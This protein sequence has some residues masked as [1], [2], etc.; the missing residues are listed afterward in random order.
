MQIAF[1]HLIFCLY[2]HILSFCSLPQRSSWLELKSIQQKRNNSISLKNGTTVLLS[3]PPSPCRRFFPS[4]PQKK[5]L[6]LGFS[7]FFSSSS[8]NKTKYISFSLF[9]N[10]EKNETKELG[11][12]RKESGLI[13]LLPIF[14]IIA[15]FSVSFSFSSCP[16]ITMPLLLHL[17]KKLL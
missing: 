14:Y 2:L 5:L 4:V 12:P 9:P 11:L 13:L 6:V 7:S 3:S 17:S 8:S 16:F 15:P 1:A 10:K